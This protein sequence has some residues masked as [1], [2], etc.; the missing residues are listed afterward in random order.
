MN[1]NSE[2]LAAVIKDSV[3]PVDFIERIGAM[4]GL[5]TTKD[6]ARKIGITT[7]HLC[8]IKHNIKRTAQIPSLKL[9]HKIANGLDIELS[10]L[11]F[12]LC[13]YKLDMFIKQ[14]LQNTKDEFDETITGTSTK[15]M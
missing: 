4:Q 1:I 13:N 3:D 8:V 15:N 10:L 11:W 14:T 6:I 12:T 5:K 7:E 9:C 2:I